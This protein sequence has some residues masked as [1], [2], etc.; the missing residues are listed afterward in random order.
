MYTIVYTRV[1]LSVHVCT[2]PSSRYDLRRVYIA[3]PSPGLPVYAS[4]VYSEENT[5]SSLVPYPRLE[6]SRIQ[7]NRILRQ[8]EKPPLD[9]F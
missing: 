9:G 6:A 5:F 1:Y 3:P 2:L 7:N 8:H 4:R